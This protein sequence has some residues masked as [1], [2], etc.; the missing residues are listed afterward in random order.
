MEIETLNGAIAIDG[1]KRAGTFLSSDFDL[2]AL[3][4]MMKQSNSWA[5]G[6]IDTLILL[7]NP[8]EKVVLTAVHEGTQITSFQTNDSVTFQIL[9]GKLRYST[10]NDSVILRK[11]QM[12]T[13]NEKIK[14]KLVAGEETVFLLTILNTNLKIAKAS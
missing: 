4:E 9:E 3:I 8:D 14:Y 2:P 1:R 13:I 12:M 11:G 7:K 10:H 5:N 6:D